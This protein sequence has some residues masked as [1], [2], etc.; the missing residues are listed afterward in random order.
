MCRRCAIET[1]IEKAAQM[2]I[3][4][5]TAIEDRLQD[6]VPQTIESLLDGGIRV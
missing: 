5:A 3:L 6:N 4:G 2:K 1:K